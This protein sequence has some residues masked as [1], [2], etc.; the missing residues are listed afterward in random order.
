MAERL[1]LHLKDLS[2]GQGATAFVVG[3]D[4]QVG[5]GEILAIVGPNGSGKSTLLQALMGVGRVFSGGAW[6]GNVDL[7]RLAPKQRAKC[8]A[9]VPQVENFVFPF[10]VRQVVAMGRLAH[11]TGFWE[12]AEDHAAIDQAMQA[13][14]VMELAERPID[15]ISGGER[16]RVL[17]ARALAQ[18][19]PILILDEPNTHLDLRHVREFVSLSQQLA[20]EGK[21]VLVA[22][23][24]LDMAAAM[25]DRF[26][27]LENG[28][29]AAQGRF[30]DSAML[31]RLGQAYGVRL[32]AAEHGG[33]RH[34]FAAR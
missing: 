17:I 29:V 33:S 16:Q 7:V 31:A 22:L 20:A 14:S 12:S 23:H 26:L 15:R 18:E 3:V 11:A 25:T 4:V 27:L 10:T 34:V 24:D 32:I 21:I 28:K 6:L 19:T 5:P 13:A 1:H 9:G 8:V 30:S 2:A